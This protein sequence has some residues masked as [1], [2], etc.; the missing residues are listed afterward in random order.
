MMRSNLFLFFAQTQFFWR[1][2][3]AI[4]HLVF[5][6]HRI[7]FGIR[8]RVQEEST[9][10]RSLLSLLR[11]VLGDLFVAILIA[12]GL[13]ITNSYFV[14]LSTEMGFTL[15]NESSYGT[16]LTTFTSI[17]G[18]FIGFYYAAISAVCGAIYARVPNN[19][20][21]LLAQERVGNA[22]M[23]FL[24][25]FT[26][27]GV[28]LLAFYALGFEPIVLAMP[29][30]LLGAGLMIVGFVR[31]G[32]RAFYLFDPTTLSGRLFEQLR[33][34]CLQMQA[35]GYRWFDQS[36]Q[37]HAHRIAQTALDTLT[38]VSDIT[39]K[40]PH[41]NGRP[42]ADLCKDLLLFLR[43]YEIIKK[44]IPTDSLWY[45]KRY[46]HQDWY[47]TG[48]TETSIGHD[49]ATDLQP[50]SASDPR[51]IE[52]AILP[53]VQRCLEIN[54]KDNRHVIVYEL[55]DYVNTYVT[56]LAR[57]HQV[58]PAFD[59]ISDVFSWCEK[60][61]ITEE[62]E[63][64]SEEP[65]EHM[66]IFDK[67]ARMPISVLIAYAYATES[68]GRDVI[69]QRIQRISWKSEK[70]IYGAEFPVH[71]LSQLEWLRTRLE[72]E[73]RIEQSVV[74]PPWYIQEL[75]AQKEAENL[76]AA[77]VCFYEEICKLYG[78]WIK[79]SMSSQHPW[80]AAAIISVESEYWSKLNYNMNILDLFWND[81]NSS[82]R[83]EELPWP[84]LD[85]DELKKKKSLREKELLKLMARENTILSSMSRPESYPDFA[86]KFLHTIGEALFTAICENDYDTVK[87]LFKR[88]FCGSSLQFEQ[89][90]P[91]EVKLDW[92]SQADLKIAVAPLLDM[93]DISG[94]AYLL[95]DYHD[96]PC[97][98]ETI[99]TVWNEYIDQN[100][101][102]I[103]LLAGAV[104]L[105]ESAFEIA[106][107][108]IN[109]T[110][111]KQIIQ[112]RLKD[113]ER[114]EVTRSRDI[115]FIGSEFVIMHKSPLVRIFAKDHSFLPF[116]GID[117]FLAKY[118]RAREDGKDLDFGRRRSRNIEEAIERENNRYTEGEE[119]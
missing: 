119:S 57:E 32:A 96:T 43:H 101:K 73:E 81:L 31:L 37:A 94:Y 88:Y 106:H 28:C 22:Y 109:R 103:Q 18:I 115:S 2:R 79:T 49:T 5:F 113:V 118:I 111:W 51:W 112:Q 44:S 77:T 110:R 25:V 59:L 102:R 99:I 10:T 64:V 68:Y 26:S 66:A 92:Q 67:L 48:D 9:K 89:L 62:D 41:L 35:G 7:L 53:I 12:F 91:E 50:Q 47:R 85:M 23:R 116:D 6:I 71:V 74:S 52:S 40:E 21:D 60:L 33:Q 54:I 3:A 75:I 55:L 82:R 58:E 42:F 65:L 61:I 63:V 11:S 80:L 39:A 19:I 38:T 70:S 34:C 107:R 15:P 56:L 104:L 97:L 98:K 17:G 8:H 78:N 84:N 93:M 46:V 29:L 83:I 69:L 1:A 114:Q 4:S 105:T 108:S 45:K 24:A 95:S 13:Q 117:I 30:L 86:G 14:T 90:R 36:F 76:H 87:T 72:F 20:R 16:L 100:I 27:L